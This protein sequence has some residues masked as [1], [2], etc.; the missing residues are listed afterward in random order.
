MGCFLQFLATKKAQVV[1]QP[2]L[3]RGVRRNH[4]PRTGKCGKDPV[5]NL[6]CF[7][8]TQMVI[9]CYVYSVKM[10]SKG[11]SNPKIL[12][13]PLSYPLVMTVT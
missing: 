11:H 4:L 12:V 9:L 1:K 2:W 13:N 7:G 8:E 3:F 6:S 5:R 10:H